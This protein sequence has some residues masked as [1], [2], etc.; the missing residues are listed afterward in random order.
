MSYPFFKCLSCQT[1]VQQVIAYDKG[2]MPYLVVSSNVPLSGVFETD[3]LFLFCRGQGFRYADRDHS[4]FMNFVDGY[5]F[6]F[7]GVFEGYCCFCALHAGFGTELFLGT[8]C[9]GCKHKQAAIEAFLDVTRS[10]PETHAQWR[11][12]GW[13]A[14]PSAIVDKILQYLVG[15]HLPV[16]DG[17]ALPPVPNGSLE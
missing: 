13:A 4:P 15:E 9:Y 10:E 2:V 11:S 6:N 3:K 5:H 8:G 17:A 1:K 14:L 7:S 16:V 12:H